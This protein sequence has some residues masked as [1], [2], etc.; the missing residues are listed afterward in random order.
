MTLGSPL[1]SEVASLLEFHLWIG[2]G[3]EA[4]ED[5]GKND[6]SCFQQL[7]EALFALLLGLRG[8]TSMLR[9]F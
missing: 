4:L 1:Y 2:N 6:E 5:T 3:E 7:L 9:C 8:K